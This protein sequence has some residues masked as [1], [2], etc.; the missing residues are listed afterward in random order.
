MILALVLAVGIGVSLGLL[1][2]GGSILTLPILVYVL[3]MEAKQ[4]IATSLLVVGVT[5]AAALVPHAR[6]GRVNV[7]IGL[8]FGASSMAGAFVGGRVAHFLPSGALLLAFALM[9]LVTGL[10]MLRGRGAS[11]ALVGKRPWGRILVVGVGI[12][13]LTGV[14]GAGGGFVIVPALALLC[15]L[16]MSEAIA[17]SL[18]VIALNSFSGFAGSIGH[19][20]LDFRVAALITAASVVGSIAGA[21][22]AGRVPEA[23]LRRAF[24]WL[25]L[26][27]AVFMLWR[28]TST[29]WGLAA[30]AA[31]IG[32]AWLFRRRTTA[33]SSDA[34]RDQ[35]TQ[36]KGAR[37][38]RTG[39]SS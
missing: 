16:S 12:G 8:A 22:A 32:G 20:T 33:A 34:T 35:G 28:Q 30:I 3:G 17:T 5:S 39:D 2:G 9:M 4:A 11:A 37:L 25:V 15:G 7:R 14:I 29:L 26:A 19:V 10:A 1:G 24:A 21:F 36:P 27:M 18:L 38:L 6:A 13:L 23:A 31:A